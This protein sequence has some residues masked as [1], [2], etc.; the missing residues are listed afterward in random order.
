MENDERQVEIWQPMLDSA[1]ADSGELF[2]LGANARDEGSGAAIGSY[3][4]IQIVGIDESALRSAFLDLMRTTGEDVSME[5][6]TLGGKS[7]LRLA[8]G[9]ETRSYLYLDGDIAHTFTMSE[10]DAARVLESMP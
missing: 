8:A 4:A 3:A 10:E 9:D 1:G 2:I 7:V 5:D 6:L